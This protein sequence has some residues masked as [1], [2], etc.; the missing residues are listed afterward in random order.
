[1]TLSKLIFYKYLLLQ[2][3]ALERLYRWTQH[4]CRN[5]DNPDFTDLI[6]HSM[7]RLEDRPILFK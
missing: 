3:K 7:S 4:H 1:M 5:V 6:T 2:E